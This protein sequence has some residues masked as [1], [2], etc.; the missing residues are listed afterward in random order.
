VDSGGRAYVAQTIDY[1]LGDATS[2]L[3]VAEADN[4]VIGF[5]L[6]GLVDVGLGIKPGAYG[7]IAH[8]CVTAHWRR[9]GIGRQLCFGLMDWLRSK[10]VSSIQ[11]Y[12]SRFSP[13]S[14]RFWRSMGFESYMERLWCDL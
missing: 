13:V 9:L 1:W 10:G 14:Q 8:M 3:L 4:D 2:H 7:H 12:V 5:T 6:G 11:I